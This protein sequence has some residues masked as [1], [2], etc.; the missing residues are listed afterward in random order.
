VTDASEHSR[1]SPR[2]PTNQQVNLAGRHYA[3]GELHRRGALDVVIGRTRGEP[4]LKAANQSRTRMI[5]I[6]VRVKT[7]GDWQVSTDFGVPHKPEGDPTSFWILVDLRESVPHYFVAPA[8]WVENNIYE[9]HQA[10]LKRHGGHRAI[11]PDSKHHRI[12]DDRVE[13]WRERWEILGIFD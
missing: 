1:A 5:E 4:D 13:E 3:A 10:Y 2:R 12:T 7:A 11:S 8:W 6:V 9:E